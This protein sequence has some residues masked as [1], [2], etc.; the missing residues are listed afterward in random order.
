MKILDV[1]VQNVSNTGLRA[2]VRGELNGETL[3]YNYLDDGDCV[4]EGMRPGLRLIVELETS[5]K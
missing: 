4:V 5:D 3:F 2:V 1:M